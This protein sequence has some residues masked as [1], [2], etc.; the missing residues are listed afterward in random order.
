MSKHYWIWK[1]QTEA[2]EDF[3]WCFESDEWGDT[4][5]CATFEQAVAATVGRQP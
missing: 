2:P 1:D 3:L 4:G 5:S